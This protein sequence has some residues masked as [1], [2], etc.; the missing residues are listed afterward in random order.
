MNASNICIFKVGKDVIDERIGYE[1]T[2]FLI[3]H[4]D[5]NAC[6]TIFEIMKI[7]C[8]HGITEKLE[9]FIDYLESRSTLEIFAEGN[10][11][12]DFYVR[13]FGNCYI[14]FNGDVGV[15][16]LV[17]NINKEVEE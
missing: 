17:E 8:S 12:F 1:E 15:Y 5:V 10:C 6:E 3:D 2:V 9:V 16:E 7:R 4:W 13:C 14:K 11:L